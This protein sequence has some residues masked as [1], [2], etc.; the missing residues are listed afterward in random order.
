[1]ML[2]TVSCFDKLLASAIVLAAHVRATTKKPRVG[3]ILP[4]GIQGVIANIAVMLA[5]NALAHSV[6]EFTLTVGFPLT[7][8]VP[9]PLPVQ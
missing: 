8:K 2:V 6:G 3:I 5:G 7:I 9:E 1:M 4:P